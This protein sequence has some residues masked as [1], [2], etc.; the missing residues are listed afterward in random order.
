[1]NKKTTK[2]LEQNSSF[3]VVFL[4]LFR[5]HAS[6]KKKGIKKQKERAVFSKKVLKPLKTLGFQAFSCCI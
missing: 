3:K 6:L 4:H 1:L 2:E 5:P